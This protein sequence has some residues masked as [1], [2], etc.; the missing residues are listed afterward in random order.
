SP[1]RRRRARGPG[2]CRCDREAEE[3]PAVAL[4][5][6]AAAALH[7]RLEGEELE[8]GAGRVA[9]SREVA[10]GDA[11]RL[12]QLPVP[13]VEDEERSASPPPPAR[14]ADSGS[15]SPERRTRLR[16]RPT[17]RARSRAR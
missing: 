11:Q 13:A 5:V 4:G 14:R 17:R 9:P 3:L 6:E 7:H 8:D 16:R 15:P 1:P 10:L 12:A 2:A